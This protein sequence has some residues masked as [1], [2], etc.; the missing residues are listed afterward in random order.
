[1]ETREKYELKQIN[2]LMPMTAMWE[3]DVASSS[4]I[5]SENWLQI[6][7]YSSHEITNLNEWAEKIHPD[8][9]NLAKDAFECYLSGKT[10]M[11]QVEMRYVCKDGSYKWLR[12][13]GVIIARDKTSIPTRIIGTHT[14]IS[15]EPTRIISEDQYREIV[16][17]SEAIICT[18]DLDGHIL[19]M[20][21][22]VQKIL[23]FL[24]DEL[25]GKSIASVVV[26]EH[27][28]AFDKKYM[29]AIKERGTS[30][31]VMKVNNN[32]GEVKYL[33]YHNH[34]FNGMSG[35]PYIIGFAQDITNRIKTE[36]ALKTS[37][38]TFSNA[39]KYSAIGMALVSTE[40]KWLEVND[41][42]CAITGYSKQ[43]LIQLSFQD[44][45]HPDDLA[46][47]L[48]LVKQM[49]SKE[50]DTYNLEKRYITKSGNIVWALLTVSLVWNADDTPKFFISQIKDITER[51]QLTDELNRKNKEL[52]AIK[53]SLL[54]KVSQLEEFSYIVAHNVRGPVKSIQMLGEVL[55]SADTQNMAFNK[56]DATNLIVDTTVSLLESLE[57][58]LSIAQIR[59]HK[60][61]ESEDCIISDTI[62][63]VCSQLHG[64][65]LEKRANIQQQI[66]IGHIHFPK[67]YLENILY[68]LISN[69]LKYSKSNIPPQI[70]IASKIENDKTVLSIKDNGLGIDLEKYGD[71]VFKLNEY[72]HHGYDSK[73]IGLY[74]VKTQV[75]SMGGT[76][77]VQSKVNEGSEFIIAI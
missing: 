67:A 41:A 44:I 20:N 42:I 74:L 36:E 19:T 60:Q 73:G 4:I 23:G 16:D 3:I 40:G 2:R 77:T 5:F 49:L 70:T 24:P 62:E 25:I 39:F 13:K 12:S 37:I 71:R 17:Y 11:Y 10:N 63:T 55:Q 53:D 76:I 38:D 8:D 9:I 18:H 7:G 26:E 33:L 35:Y 69:A 47:D 46:A 21:P 27:R 56:T 66:E 45:T 48:N 72:F 28:S 50:I 58:L 31:G 22:A 32:K 75:E 51:R 1:M 64:V 57:T 34:L 15:V 65:I 30:E 52:E 68:N 14:A 6:F 59:M 43:E 29:E 61:I 54:N